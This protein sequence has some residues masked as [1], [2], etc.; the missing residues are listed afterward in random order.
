MVGEIGLCI[1]HAEELDDR[2][3][4]IEGAER[5]LGDGKEQKPGLPR[6]G[7]GLLDRRIAPEPADAVGAVSL[8]RALAGEKR[9]LPASRNGT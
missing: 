7:I 1:D 3:D 9:R 8:S 4:A 5:Q 6:V 2:L